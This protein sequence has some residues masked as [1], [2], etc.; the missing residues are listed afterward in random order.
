MS[1][2]S[3]IAEAT[4]ENF[5][6][7]VGTGTVLVDVWGPDC[8]PC[9]AL[10]PAVASLAERQA[11]WLSVVKLEAPKARRLCMELKVMSMPAFILFQ[12]G[13]EKARLSD[14]ALNVMQLNQW[15]NEQKKEVS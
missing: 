2:T 6:D 11:D 7:L 12:D 14:P 9:L 15:V 4:K 1:D 13:Q 8:R 3:T 10:M 5:W